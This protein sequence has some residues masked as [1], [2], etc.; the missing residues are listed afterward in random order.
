MEGEE[1]N[2]DQHFLNPDRNNVF[3]SQETEILT[4]D[5]VLI[6]PVVCKPLLKVESEKKA[7]QKFDSLTEV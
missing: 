6:E 2:L 4:Q 3:S 7:E 1:K 5:T